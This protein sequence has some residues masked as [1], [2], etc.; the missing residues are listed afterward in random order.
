MR[1]P[2]QLSAVHVAGPVLASTVEPQYPKRCGRHQGR[3]QIYRRQI[4]R[5]DVPQVRHGHSQVR[6]LLFQRKKKEG[7]RD[8]LIGVK[9]D[10]L[11]DLR[12]TTLNKYRSQKARDS[13]LGL[14][15]L[16]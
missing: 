4:I 9:W 2:I 3:C 6:N 7:T 15:I 5:S 14:H 8:R 11:L 16:P 13:Q 1:G 10:I 12:L